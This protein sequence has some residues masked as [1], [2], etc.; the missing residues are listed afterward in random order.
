MWVGVGIIILRAFSA[1]CKIEDYVF[2]NYEVKTAFHFDFLK[3]AIFA[4]II[5][6][7]IRKRET[8]PKN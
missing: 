5:I 3:D 7:I 8:H 4:K 6:I 1:I 2:M